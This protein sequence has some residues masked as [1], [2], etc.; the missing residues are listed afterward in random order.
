MDTIRIENLEIYAY[1]G[2][3]EEEKKLGQRFFI[4]AELGADLKAAASRDDIELSVDYG[5]IAQEML[6]FATENRWNLIETLADRLAADL[7]LRFKGLT[8][9]K[10]QV[11]KPG[12]P[13][14][15]PI[16]NI[17]VTA[18]RKKTMAFVALGSN[19]GDRNAYLSRAVELTEKEEGI[20]LIKVSKFIETD[21][22][23]KTDQND[24]LNAV[25]M[26][27]TILTPQELLDFCHQL[28]KDA[29]RVR[30]ELWGPRT[31]DAD[32]LFYGREIISTE[33]LNIPHPDLVNRD[34]VLI[35]MEEV[36]PWFTDP[37]TG[38]TM[39]RLLADYYKNRK[40]HTR[41]KENGLK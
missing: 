29:K 12:A 7:L 2:V 28:E 21:P 31:L 11:S 30:K 39:A 25:M 6:R 35:P 26:I 15:L 24:F 14:P 16:Q 5:A 23:G 1:H 4:T 3:M 17:S 33:N 40:S 10:I 38:K 20:R 32:I 18:E 27:E 19:M 13:V 36:A 22:Y 9:A 37:L 34:F 41:K 8:S